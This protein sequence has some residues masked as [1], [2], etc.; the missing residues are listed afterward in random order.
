[1]KRGH[2]I[3]TGAAL[4]VA[5]ASTGYILYAYVTPTS[6][7]AAAPHAMKPAALER[8]PE[9]SLS[10]L[11]GN[12]RSVSEWDGRVL[13]VNFWA[14]WCAPCLKEIPAFVA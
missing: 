7:R 8:R 10:D 6:S 5:A 2:L 13:L 12:T 3:L 4:A 9:F 11:T 14:T 1:M